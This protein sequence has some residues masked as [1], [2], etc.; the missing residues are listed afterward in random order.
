MSRIVRVVE[1][2]LASA[3]LFWP[4]YLGLVLAAITKRGEFVVV[5]MMGSCLWV[6][7]LVALIRISKRL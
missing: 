7:V 4:A 2:F 1:Y 3:V 6:L 5:G